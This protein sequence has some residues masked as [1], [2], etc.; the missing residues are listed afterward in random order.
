MPLLH[1]RPAFSWSAHVCLCYENSVLIVSTALSE[2][3]ASMA[4]GDF[5]THCMQQAWSMHKLIAHHALQM[6]VMSLHNAGAAL[7]SKRNPRLLAQAKPSPELTSRVRMPSCTKPMYRWEN[8]A[9]VPGA[10]MSRPSI[11]VKVP[12]LS[13][14][15]TMPCEAASVLC[16]KAST[17][18]GAATAARYTCWKPADCSL[19]ASLTY[20]DTKAS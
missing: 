1:S 16:T 15:P 19:D 7:T 3:D 11:L 18:S 13:E 5:S 12:S 10:L 9:L 4:S 8:G 20:P 6:A 14:R 17:S 2:L